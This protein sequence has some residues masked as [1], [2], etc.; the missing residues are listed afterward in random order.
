MRLI[1]NNIWVVLVFIF[2]IS[3]NSQ[4]S[5][6]YDYLKKVTKFNIKDFD[7]WTVSME[8]P[9]DIDEILIEYK[10]E[11]NDTLMRLQIIVKINEESEKIIDEKMLV[12]IFKD[13]FMQEA[14]LIS[15]YDT[16]F[17]YTVP[18]NN[19]HDFTFIVGKY[20]YMYRSLDLTRGQEL[21]YEK[22]RDSLKKVHGNVLP[23]LPELEYEE[24]LFIFEVAE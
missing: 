1:M 2:A 10:K 22:H 20:E 5:G 23:S 16:S 8:M 4:T 12:T 3:C 21:Y 13:T 7:K 11:S 17:M 6:S 9:N 24:E 14:R 15:D 18:I 19:K